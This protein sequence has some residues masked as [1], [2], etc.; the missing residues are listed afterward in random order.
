MPYERPTPNPKIRTQAHNASVRIQ[1]GEFVGKASSLD[2]VQLKI[3]QL[4]EYWRK[5][6]QP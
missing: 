4:Q 1:V 6:H 3:Q 2:S 5:V